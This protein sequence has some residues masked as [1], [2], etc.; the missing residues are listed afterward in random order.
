MKLKFGTAL[1]A[2]SA[3]ALLQVQPLAGQGK[4]TFQRFPIDNVYINGM[5]ADG[6]VVVGKY[7]LPERLDRHAFRWTALDG[8]QDIGGDMDAVFISR[9]G[10]TIVGTERDSEGNAQAAIWQGGQNWRLLFKTAI[11]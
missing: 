3:F 5:S 11:G 2:I 4:L 9:D 8:L 7:I 6:N 1:Y 10:K